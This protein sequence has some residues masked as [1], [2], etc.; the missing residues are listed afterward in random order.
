VIV[1]RR[2]PESKMEASINNDEQ[3]EEE[4]EKELKEVVISLKIGEIEN[5][6]T[7]VEDR[8]SLLLINSHL[9]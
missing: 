9:R 2:K 4:N 5:I 3:I 1:R 8:Q 7:V 6:F